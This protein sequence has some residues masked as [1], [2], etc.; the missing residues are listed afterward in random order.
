MKYVR[1]A[2]INI[3]GIRIAFVYGSFA[4]GDERKDSDIDLFL[5]GDDIDDDNLISTISGLEKELFREVN[6]T[7]YTENEYKKEKQKKDS[8]VA[9][10]IK[11]KKLFIKGT[12]NEL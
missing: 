6:Y 12:A 1:E 11:G 10:V 2:V 3:N 5:I 4:K 8:F 7:A 9:E